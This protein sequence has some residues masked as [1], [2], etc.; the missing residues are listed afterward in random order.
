MARL[1]L[2][3]FDSGS[4]GPRGSPELH[5]LRLSP[6]LTSRHKKN[7]FDPKALKGEREPEVFLSAA[8]LSTQ[9]VRPSSLSAPRPV[10][11]QQKKLRANSTAA[12]AGEQEGVGVSRSFIETNKELNWSIC[13]I[14]NLNLKS[15]GIQWW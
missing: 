8:L 3:P 11:F 9:R 2:T 7:V 1:E 4:G 15:P 14:R 5:R 13:S 12:G 6:H 10:Q